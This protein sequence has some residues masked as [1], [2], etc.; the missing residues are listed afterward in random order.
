M[1]VDICSGWVEIPAYDAMMDVVARATSRAFVGLPLCTYCVIALMI[2][3]FF[4]KLLIYPLTGRDPGFLKLV[5]KYT[6]DVVIGA[7]ILLMFPSILRS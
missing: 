5:I 7:K 6:Y 1:T 2:V 3:P 4:L